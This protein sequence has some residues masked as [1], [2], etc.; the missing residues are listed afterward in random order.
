MRKVSLALRG[1][2]GEMNRVGECLKRDVASECPAVKAGI[3]LAAA[4]FSV[5]GPS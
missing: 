5:S 4:S 1:N 3:D 2:F